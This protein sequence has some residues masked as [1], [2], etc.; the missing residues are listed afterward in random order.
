MKNK[1]NKQ[2]PGSRSAKERCKLIGSGTDLEKIIK[3]K[4]RLFVLFYASWCPFSQKF[5][6]EFIESSIIR[7]ECHVRIVIDDKEE[8]I[9]KYGIKVYPTV[10]YFR[11]GKLTKRLDGTADVGLNE[12]QLKDFIE[13]CVRKK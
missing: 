8:V 13:V 11:N 12:R 3:E 4:E 10:L 2:R 9:D 5:L 6:P 1:P 7:G